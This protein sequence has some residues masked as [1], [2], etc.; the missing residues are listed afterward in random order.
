MFR[1]SYKNTTEKVKYYKFVTF[2]PHTT[3][4]NHKYMKAAAPTQMR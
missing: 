4:S 2:L 1:N 3:S